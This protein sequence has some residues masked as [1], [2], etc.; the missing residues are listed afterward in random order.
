MIA[1][2]DLEIF[3]NVV[4]NTS[5]AVTSHHDGGADAAQAVNLYGG[6]RVKG[7]SLATLNSALY[8]PSPLPFLKPLPRTS[9]AP[10][11][12]VVTT[13][14]PSHLVNDRS[15]FT[16]YTPSHRVYQTAF[17]AEITIEGT[18]NVEV[19]VLAGGK[20]I[21]F[22][23]HD[24]W[25]VPS[26]PHHFLSGLPVTVTWHS[27]PPPLPSLPLKTNPDHSRIPHIYSRI[28]NSS[29]NLLSPLALLRITLL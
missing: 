9:M 18:G 26:S 15:L 29:R 20:F 8:K 5:A 7:D 23:I 24:C 17:G 13:V 6:D 1:V 11:Y 16:T 28:L 19:C 2:Q 27:D 21:I 25:H 14:L 12:F 22:T 4:S 10:Q 3:P